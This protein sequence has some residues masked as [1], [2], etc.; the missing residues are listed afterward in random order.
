LLLAVLEWVKGIE[1][2]TSIVKSMLPEEVVC[3]KFKNYSIYLIAK[4]GH[5]PKKGLHLKKIV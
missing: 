5:Q 3:L 4:R 2:L 1:Y